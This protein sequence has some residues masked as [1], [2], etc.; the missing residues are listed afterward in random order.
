MR[1]GCATNNVFDWRGPCHTTDGSDIGIDLTGGY[2]DAGDH[3]KFGLPQ[4]YTAA[5]LG[6]SLYEYKDVFDSTGDTQSCSAPLNTLP[7]IC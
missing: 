6:W 3:V 7:I 1:T 4:A 5:I 2:H